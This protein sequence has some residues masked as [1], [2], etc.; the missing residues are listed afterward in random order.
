MNYLDLCHFW[1]RRPQ[2]ICSWRCLFSKEG[3]N[4]PFLRKQISEFGLLPNDQEQID[5]AGGPKKLQNRDYDVLGVG[6]LIIDHILLVPDAFLEELGMEKGGWRSVDYPTL[7]EILQKSDKAP[8][9]VPGGSAANSL[10][11]LARLGQKVSMIGKIGNDTMGK[12]YSDAMQERGV[13]IQEIRSEEQT[14]EL[15][16]LVTPDGQR[17]FCIFQGTSVTFSGKDLTPD[18]FTGIKLVHIEGYTLF[19]DDLTE[20][21][22]ALAKA[23]GAKVSFDLAS[24][25]IVRRFKEKIYHLLK[26]YVDIVFCNEDEAKMLTG[27]TEEETCQMLGSICEVAVVS[28]GSRGCYIQHEH[29][30]LYCPAFYVASP[31]DTTGAGDLFASGFLHGYLNN[32]PLHVAATYGARAGASVIQVSG[33]EIPEEG[34]REILHAIHSAELCQT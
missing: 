8:T 10:K 2:D 3:V 1:D 30:L 24:F 34:W 23:A 28:L 18:H 20:R 33:G 6:G 12:F 9:T 15:I 14:A 27:H 32:Q 22:M 4:N 26:E 16:A 31:L 13:R 19:N 5:E 7:Q 25:E 11:G 29:E 17:S 21:A